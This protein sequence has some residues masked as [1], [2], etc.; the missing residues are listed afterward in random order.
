MKQNDIKIKGLKKTKEELG[1]KDWGH[2]FLVGH[3][4][5]FEKHHIP[6]DFKEESYNVE[7]IANFNNPKIGE[8]IA[9]AF[10][11]LTRH[12]GEI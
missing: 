3:A 1:I 11:F 2:F 7:G 6:E 4:F 9:R 5:R 12:S 10:D 8:S